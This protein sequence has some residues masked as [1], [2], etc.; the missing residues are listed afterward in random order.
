MDAYD[1]NKNLNTVLEVDSKHLW[2]RTILFVLAFVIAIAAFTKGFLSLGAQDPGYYE[3]TAAPVEDAMYYA[4]GIKYTAWFDGS[5]SEIKDRMKQ[6]EKDYSA[7]LQFAYKLLDPE[8]EYEGFVNIASINMAAREGE[9]MQLSSQTGDV[10][11][12]RDGSYFVSRELVIP[13]ELYAVLKDA[14]GKTNVM[15]SPSPVSSLLMPGPYSVFAGALYREWKQILIDADAQSFDPELN[16]SEASRMAAIASLSASNAYFDILFIDDEKCVIRA[17][18]ASEAV[19]A[20]KQYEIEDAPVIDLNLLHDAYMIQI[21]N[22]MM[23]SKGW[24]KGVFQNYSGLTVIQAD[25]PDENGKRY[26]SEGNLFVSD[27]IS[28]TALNEKDY[29]HYD[30]EINGEVQ[31][32]SIYFDLRTGQPSRG[33][34]D[35]DLLEKETASIPDTVFEHLIDYFK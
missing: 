14:V 19:S 10:R 31:H 28:A 16:T 20:L 23:A 8:N 13:P 33:K 35:Q 1:P 25:A 2:A 17:L 24:D 11:A 3:L 34:K 15:T 30:V 4:S 26:V 7:A 22:G 5:S 27:M 6:A 21:V 18:R 29:Y 12:P 32:R 9:L